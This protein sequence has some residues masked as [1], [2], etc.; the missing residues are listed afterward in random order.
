MAAIFHSQITV[1][2]IPIFKYSYIE[3][4]VKSVLNQPRESIIVILANDY[5]L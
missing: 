3:N 5:S 1:V 4:V 2:V